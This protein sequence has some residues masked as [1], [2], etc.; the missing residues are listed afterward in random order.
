MSF[1]ENLTTLVK[2]EIN[3]PKLTSIAVHLFHDIKIDKLFH[4]E[5][6][7]DN[8]NI[9][10]NINLAQLKEKERIKWQEIIKVSIENE[11]KL[12][13]EDSATKLLESFEQEEKKSEYAEITDFF[14]HKIPSSDLEILR[15]SL[16]IKSLYDKGEPVRDLKSG[17]MY[18]Y[19]ER[20]RNISNLCSAGY[21]TSYIKPLYL[22]MESQENFSNQDFIKV[23][24]IIIKHS[25]FAIF[26]NSQMSLDEL[27]NQ[28]AQSMEFNKSYGISHL[29]IH[30]IGSMNIFKIQEA[31]VKIK[32][33][34]SSPPEIESTSKYITVTIYF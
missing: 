16:Y 25:A 11:D 3:F 32:D 14:K 19:G 27:N 33:N 31:L 12:L 30:G 13:L 1:L 6:Y 10:V 22:E 20:G 24:N 5:N 2:G 28:I 34:L 18:K 4:I 17:L 26:V 9:T 8:R 7:N 23:Y 29:N 15:A 21:F